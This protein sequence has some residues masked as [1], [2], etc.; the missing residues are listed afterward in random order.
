MT[1]F[2]DLETE[3]E[4]D[5][6]PGRDC[7]KKGTAAFTGEDPDK[8]KAPAWGVIGTT[9]DSNCYLGVRSKIAAVQRAMSQYVAR[10]D[11]F[12][13]IIDFVTTIGVSDG[14]L[15]GTP[16]MRYSLISRIL[17]MEAALLHFF[18]AKLEAVIAVVACDKPPVGIVSAIL[19]YNRPAIVYPDGPIGFG[20]DPVTGKRLGI[21]TGFQQAGNPDKEVRDRIARFACPGIGSCG[22]MYT[23]NTMQ[24]FFA[25]LGLV[26]I[27]MVSPAS[28]DP[29]RMNEFPDRL[30]AYLH[31]MVEQGIRPR[32]VKRRDGKKDTRPVLVTAAS[33]RNAVIV[34]MAMGGSTNVQLHMVEL[35]KA[36][37]V[38]FW[39]DI[40]SQKEF[41]E[42]S[43]LVPV[44]VDLLPFGDPDNQY[45]MVDVDRVGGLQAIVKELL[46]A[47][48]LDGSCLSC[49]GETLAEQ[50][51]RLDPPAPDHEV[52]YSV[53]NPFQPTGGLR[54]LS[55]NLA[56][57]GGTAIKIAGINLD[58]L[59]DGVFTGQA[60][61]FDSEVALL[62]ALVHDP[63]S[64]V[65]RTM[66]VIRY[67]GPR[68][69]PGMPELLD[70]TSRI[71]TLCK[72]RGIVIAL[73]TDAR[74]SGGSVGLVMGHVAPE[75]MLGG[76]IALVQNGDTIIVDLNENTLNCL[77]LD[78][79]QEEMCRREDW[80]HELNQNGGVHPSV[81]SIDED[82]VILN[83]MRNSGLPA[84]E[85]SGMMY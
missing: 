49:T 18:S 46:D 43:A 48:F 55:G 66:V 23:Y 57:Y 63:D 75:A 4:E 28:S 59:V 84:M 1:A 44:L 2:T 9:G 3:V 32:R 22:G 14:S 80:Q 24:V 56:P 65:D 64:F 38:N 27:D 76:P 34:D 15:N 68:G 47:G 7:Q 60:R 83:R 20:I 31:H 54:F 21:V 36:A 52:I 17:V 19:R 81:P 73:M 50:I 30:V 82:D 72:E 26:P 25:L 33:F 74:F 42:L 10:L 37:K 41:N 13:R 77:E 5:D 11:L 58:S 69:A 62:E 29:R 45:V 71:T 40:M 35:A 51:V 12:V 61:T 8:T 79:D 85:G 53:A 67:L 39:K 6:N 78:S 16:R 70:P